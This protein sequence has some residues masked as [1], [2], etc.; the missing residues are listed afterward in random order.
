M[1]IASPLDQRAG[2]VQDEQLRDAS[3]VNGSMSLKAAIA[4]L[5]HSLYVDFADHWQL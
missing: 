2:A 5:E 4:R 1:L 3:Y